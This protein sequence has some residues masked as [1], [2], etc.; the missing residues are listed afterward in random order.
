MFKTKNT[1][2]ALAISAVV[3]C[4]AFAMLL[5]T[6]F[7]WF[8][9]TASTK[10]NTIVTGDFEI[11]IKA[12]NAD[13]SYGASLKDTT[14]SFVNVQAGALW[15]PGMVVRTEEFAIV[16]EGD[17]ALKFKIQDVFANAV[18][19]GGADLTDVIT[20]TV[21]T[22][23][24]EILYSN[25]D[26]QGNVLDETTRTES[27][28]VTLIKG[29]SAVY[30]IEFNLLSTAGNEYQECSLDGAAVCITATQA[31]VEAETDSEGYTYDA[32]ATYPDY[33]EPAQ[34]P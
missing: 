14:L 7:A 20:Y 17:Y 16:N 5:G 29:A 9:D 1:G 22:Q 12:V 25:V 34:N 4:V 28:E 18:V 2:R 19:T 15:E 3:I 21:Y 31:S 23:G 6:T 10:V 27:P 13:G 11:D 32:N 26:A 24:G 33:E 8:T 30:Y